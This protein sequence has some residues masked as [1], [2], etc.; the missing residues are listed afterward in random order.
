MPTAEVN[1][2][3]S[4]LRISGLWEVER[5]LHMVRGGRVE[6][7]QPIVRHGLV[8]EPCFAP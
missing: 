6:F 7:Q 5:L 3:T 1:A 4:L 8:G 2:S